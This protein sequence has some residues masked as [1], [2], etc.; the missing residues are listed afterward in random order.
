MAKIERTTTDQHK[1]VVEK[2]NKLITNTLQNKTELYANRLTCEIAIETLNSSFYKERLASMTMIE[3]LTKMKSL[4]EVIKHI[5]DLINIARGNLELLR[6]EQ[7]EN[8]LPGLAQENKN[9]PARTH[10]Q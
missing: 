9:R 2:R 5:N 7:L 10:N 4:H 3:Y 1:E 8:N 6:N